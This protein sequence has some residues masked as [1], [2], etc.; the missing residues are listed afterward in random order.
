MRTAGRLEVSDLYRFDENDEDRKKTQRSEHSENTAVLGK[1]RFN[2]VRRARKLKVNKSLRDRTRSGQSMNSALCSLSTLAEHVDPCKDEDSDNDSDSD[3]DSDSDSDSDSDDD[4]NHGQC[5][6]KVI[7]KGTFWSRVANNRE[8]PDSLVREV[9]A[10]AMLSQ[11]RDYYMRKKDDPPPP[12]F[13]LENFLG[14]PLRHL[15]DCPRIHN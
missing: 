14:P 3:K 4:P 6:L 15:R 9:L 10:Q 13:V 11:G 5:A 12:P 2:I 1:G 7:D 8:K